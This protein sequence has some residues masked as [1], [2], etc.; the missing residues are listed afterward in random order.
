M[1]LMCWDINIVHRP[2]SQLVHA[3]YWSCLGSDIKYDPLLCDH[4]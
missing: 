1:K 4:L 3:A 2:D